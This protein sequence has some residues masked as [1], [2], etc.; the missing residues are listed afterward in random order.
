MC[1][2]FDSVCEQCAICLGVIVIL[3]V[4]VMEVFSVSEGATLDIPCMVF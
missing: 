4:T 1:C 2:V 3:L